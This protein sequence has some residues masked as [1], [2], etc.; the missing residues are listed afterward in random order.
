MVP[1]CILLVSFVFLT[2]ANRYLLGGKLA[3]GFIGRIALSLM[4]LFTGLAHFFKTDAMVLSM[5]DFFPFKRE[6]VYGTGGIEL[7]AAAG[8]LIPLTQRFAAILLIVFLICVLP[9]NIIGSMK[10]VE[11]GGMENGPL[12]LW[13]RI[14]L[15]FIFIGWTYYFGIKKALA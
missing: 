12:Y 7:L 9:A 10:R 1:L 14:P 15:Q 6:T 4:L 13:F 11:L 8:M 3:A 5:P 2:L